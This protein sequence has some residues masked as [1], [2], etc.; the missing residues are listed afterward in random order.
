MTRTATSQFS[1]ADSEFFEQG[2]RLEPML[3]ASSDFIDGKGH[4]IE[5]VRRDLDRG[6]KNPHIGCGC[7]TAQQVLRSLVLQQVKNWDYRKLR[8]RIADGYTLRI[9]ARFYSRLVPKHDAFNRAFNRLTPATL[10]VIN[11]L[12]VM[13][14]VD[15]GLENGRKLRVHTSVVETDILSTAVDKISNAEPIVIQS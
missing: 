15:L 10:E 14:A 2:V 12:V 13:S 4:V 1:F 3:Q 11:E 9:F 8:E 7:P 6:L 5:K